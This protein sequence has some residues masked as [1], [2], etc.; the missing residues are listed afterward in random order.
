MCHKLKAIT[1]KLNK[2]NQ[3]CH[4]KFVLSEGKMR[5][6][7]KRGYADKNDTNNKKT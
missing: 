2:A 6:S 1:I 3:G 7:S 4:L 5:S